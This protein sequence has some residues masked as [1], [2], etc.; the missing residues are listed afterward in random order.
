MRRI[1]RRRRHAR[2]KVIKVTMSKQETTDFKQEQATSPAWLK[3]QQARHPKRPAPMD[4]VNGIF[5]DFSEIHGDRA[6][7]DDEAVVC[8]M[9]RLESHQVMVIGIRKGTTL[10]E[11][12]KTNFGM[13][14]PEGYRKALRC[15]RIAEKFGRPVISII[16]V[17]A[18]YPGP[19]AEERG[20]AEAIAR[21][22]R[23]L[24]RLRVPT[25]S[26]ISGE[27]G[28]GGALA[29]AVADRALMLENAVYFVAPPEFAASLTWRN[30]EQ[31]HLAAKAM[32]VSAPEILQ[33]RCVDEIVP[34]PPG[35]AH[36]DPAAAAEL[37][38]EALKKNLIELKVIPPETLVADRQRKLR[39]IARFY[40]QA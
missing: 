33:L 22:L 27:G 23:E 18:A 29:L 13:P 24:S 40:R 30:P 4:F 37:L 5:V 16:D 15:M 28:S 2:I 8:G 36:A 9:A 25:V 3:V 12:I 31:K 17:T 7:G 1:I 19:G 20:Q 6:F 34:E 21:N 11:R 10:K 14:N 38:K 35:G 39:D 26:V 32:R